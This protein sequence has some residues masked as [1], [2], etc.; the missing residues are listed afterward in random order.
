[1]QQLKIR[2][3]ALFLLHFQLGWQPGPLLPSSCCSLRQRH[4]LPPAPSWS[5]LAG[6]VGPPWAA[7]LSTPPSSCFTGSVPCPAPQTQSLQPRGRTSGV[8]SLPVHLR[9]VTDPAGRGADEGVGGSNQFPL[10][11]FVQQAP[12]GEVGN[13]IRGSLLHHPPDLKE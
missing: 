2:H 3:V 7:Q 12:A 4:R 11:V 6:E 13:H 9:G 10:Q 5:I 8:M 1:M